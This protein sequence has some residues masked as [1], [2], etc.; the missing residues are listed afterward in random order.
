[1]EDIVEIPVQEEQ[2]VPP[3]EDPPLKKLYKGLVEEKLY[4]KTYDDFVKKY[5]TPEAIDELH[6]GLIEEKL[7]SKSRDEF[8]KQYFS[9]LKKKL[10][11]SV[12]L[13][14]SSLTALPSEVQ[15]PSESVIPTVDLGQARP[16]DNTPEGNRPASDNPIDLALYSN[17]LKN[18]TKKEIM[19]G[20][21]HKSEMDVPDTESVN[22]SKTIEDELKAKGFDTNKIYEK[23]K[24]VPPE[25]YNLPTFSKDELAQEL[26]D[27][28][29]KLERRLATGKWQL[30]FKASLNDELNKGNL[31]PELHD[32]I[33]H[34]ILSIQNNSDVGDYDQKRKGIQEEYNLLMKY[35]GDN[36]DKLLKNLAIDRAKTYGESFNTGFS[37]SAKKDPNSQYLDNDQLLAMQYLQDTDPETAQGYSNA[38]IDPKKIEGNPDAKAGWE[39]KMLRLKQIGVGLQQSHIQ[40]EINDLQKIA[41]QNGRL[42]PEQQKKGEDLTLKQ[43][44]LN[45]QLS[46]SNTKYWTPNYYNRDAA[47]QELLGQKNTGITH[48]LNQ[49]GGAIINTFEG[50]GDLATEPFRGDESSKIHQLEAAGESMGSENLNY[51]TQKNAALQNFEL[52]LSPTLQTQV[53]SIKNDDKLDDQQKYDKTYNLLRDN[54]SDWGRVP[55]KGGKVN[56]SPSSLFYSVSGLASQLVPFMALEAATGGGATAGLGRKLLSSFTAA[57]ATSFHDEYANAVREGVANPFSHALRVTAINSAALAGAQTPDA[58]RSMLGTKTAI[59]EM[60]S[61]MTND[62]IEAMMKAKPTAL[63]SFSKAIGKS[64]GESTK[65]GAKITAFTTGGQIANELISG[66]EIDPEQLAKSALVSTLT[67]SLAGGLGG[68]KGKYDKV[69][70]LQ[71]DALIKASQ[72]PELHIEAANEQLKNGAINPEQFNQ[73]KT[74]I[75]KAADISKKVSFVDNKGEPLSN[76]NAAKLL[77]LKMQESDIKETIKGDVPEKLKEKGDEKLAELKTEMEDVY[78]NKEEA[79]DTKLSKPIEG[80]DEQGI[81]IGKNVPTP[82]DVKVEGSGV[83][84]DKTFITHNKEVVSGKKLTDAINKVADNMVDGA[85]KK[86]QQD[87]ASHITEKQKDDFLAKDLKKRKK[88]E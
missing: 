62:E 74:N 83:G 14:K 56:I 13:E 24:D 59:G 27:N 72:Q 44:E 67:F 41:Q 65:A 49:T 42:T 26:K 70:N 79:V 11:G 51:V 76:K 7:Y 37:E 69:S 75:E 78:K 86:R 16:E 33:W 82:V 40:E 23:F 17:E 87:Y 46:E 60:V 54:P 6:K 63:K 1:M 43:E 57:A 25:L 58:I 2:Q 66:K 34:S 77:L 35:G 53:D 20:D 80:L 9:D 64:F 36:R 30:G 71:S 39:D 18:K 38:L 88:D 31:T 8:Q 47:V 73:I 61:K 85:N 22:Y 52:K 48:L 12:D 32:N 28:P 19:Y 3:Q 81:P 84:G 4:S 21:R 5:S 55:I 45:Q 29:Q 10:H 15:S 50:I 68:L